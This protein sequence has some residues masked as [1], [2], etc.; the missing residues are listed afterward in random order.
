NWTGTIS[1]SKTGWG[2]NPWQLA[3]SNVISDIT[4]QDFAAFQPVI[5]GHVYSDGDGVEN[6]T[7]SDL[8][9]TFTATTDPNGYYELTV[10]YNWSGTIKA[11]P[12]SMAFIPAQYDFSGL[13]TDVNGIDFDETVRLLNR[14]WK[15]NYSNHDAYSTRWTGGF[16]ET[17]VNSTILKVGYDRRYDTY[18][19]CG[20]RF[21]SFDVARQAVILDAYLTLIRATSVPAYEYI[22][23][24]GEKNPDAPPFSSSGPSL[25]T[26][27]RTYAKKTWG[28]TGGSAN[29]PHVIRELEGIV[30]EIT[31]LPGWSPGNAIVFLLDSA[32]TDD[33][34]SPFTFYAIDYSLSKQGLLTVNYKYAP[35][36]SGRVITAQGQAVPDVQLN[37]DNGGG[38]ALTDSL[39]YY[40]LCV[41]PE[42]SG[43]ITPNKDFWA[44]EL[45][46]RTYQNVYSDKINQ[47]FTGIA[48]VTISGSAKDVND[49]PI[50]DVSVSADNGG[51]TG[52][53][54]D[55]GYYE[56]MVPYDW[57]G[58]ISAS[59]PLWFFE[60]NEL[61]YENLSEDATNQDFT[62]TAGVILSGY[63][64]NINEGGI[65]G[66]EVEANNGGKIGTT[67]SNGFYELAVLPGW[68][69]K[70]KPGKKG[71]NFTPTVRSY[72]NLAGDLTNQNFVSLALRV[73]ADGSGDF[74]TIQQAI[75]A[76]FDGDEVIIEPGI[77]NGTGNYNIYFWG[78]A[79]TVRSVAPNNPAIV[80]ATIIEPNTITIGFRFQRAE[81]ADSVVDGITIRR[82]IGT[83][84]IYCSRGSPSIYCSYSSALISNCVIRNNSGSG[85]RCSKS[86]LNVRNCIFTGNRGAY[87]DYHAETS[88]GG[89]IWFLGENISITNCTFS[90]NAADF[91]GGV[92][93]YTSSNEM[94][95]M[96]ISNCIFRDNDAND[97]PQIALT[98]YYKDKPSTVSVSYSDVQGGEAAVYI[99]PSGTL[100]W[101]DGNLDI[102]P[103]FAVPGYWDLNG[104]PEDVNDDFWVDGDYHLKS[105]SGR[106]EP[107]SQ[108]WVYDTNTSSCIDAVRALMP[109]TPIQIG[110]RNYGPTISESTWGPMAAPPRQAC[111]Y[112]IQVILQT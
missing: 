23:T 39:G 82:C 50:A 10:D 28:W 53:T 65:E 75:D 74:P 4:N 37:A 5:S 88:R 73:C 49:V 64:I 54:G 31:S 70:I 77:Y 51:G 15:V 98:P 38:S 48:P 94:N 61:T 111:H 44:F 110:P 36:I 32:Y 33:T 66:V 35:R 107:N 41:P 79:I 105:E 29:T 109:A 84:A 85:L 68:S 22:C 96:T 63:V 83:A 13:L 16:E 80:A 45:S 11:K 92:C 95:K 26:R 8:T 14:T 108:I 71:R 30:E 89:G 46:P 69:G 58:A 42:W 93:S 7:V 60:P 21:A 52:V 78:K 20:L 55:D 34:S 40:E 76:A 17:N 100:E 90:G 99:E 101:G 59:N 19:T 43:I 86:E 24:R 2:F 102:D 12:E 62:G 112:Q 6:A 81:Q 106:W 25:W 97:G 67:D 18:M 72:S 103:C 57:S 1:V 91:G 47:N 9:E 3:Y 87:S 104:T 56:L 27:S